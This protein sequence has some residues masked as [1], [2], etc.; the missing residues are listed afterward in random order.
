VPCRQ[1]SYIE[2][3]RLELFGT[4]VRSERLGGGGI[5]ALAF[6]EPIAESEVL[7]IRQFAEDFELRQRQAL[8]D[9]VRRWVTGEK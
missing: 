5:N 9:Q 6:D 3:A 7:A 2:V 4:V 1:S 8:R